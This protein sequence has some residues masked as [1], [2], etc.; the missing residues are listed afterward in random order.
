MK[1]IAKIKG[2]RPVCPFCSGDMDLEN[3]RLYDKFEGQTEVERQKWRCACGFTAGFE[4]DLSKEE[5]G[6]E[7]RERGNQKK[8]D[9]PDGKSLKEVARENMDA[10]RE[11]LQ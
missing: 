11:S 9:L 6:V 8:L 4:F 2:S 7:F 10:L 1:R 3:I 5:F